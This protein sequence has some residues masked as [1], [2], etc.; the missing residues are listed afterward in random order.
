MS[1][2]DRTALRKFVHDARTP[3]TVVTG[4]ADLLL[5]SGDTMTEQQRRDAV[6]RIADGA[7]QLRGLLDDLDASGGVPGARRP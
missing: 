4:F 5:R 1:D 7:T 3:V 2:D 6:Q